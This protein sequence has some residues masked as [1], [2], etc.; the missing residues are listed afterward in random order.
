M[1]SFFS[2][3]PS[4]EGTGRS[5]FLGDA[6]ICWSVLFQTHDLHQLKIMQQILFDSFAGLPWM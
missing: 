6:S 3:M 4:P 5:I 1:D 2:V